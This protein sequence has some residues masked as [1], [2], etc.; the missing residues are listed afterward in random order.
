MVAGCIKLEEPLGLTALLGRIAY[1][2]C[3]AAFLAF[4]SILIF[5]FNVVLGGGNKHV[6]PVTTG[7]ESRSSLPFGPLHLISPILS[8]LSLRTGCRGRFSSPE[9][10]RADDDKTTMYRGI[11]NVPLSV[12]NTLHEQPQLHDLD[13]T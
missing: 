7:E 13:D 6:M 12:L 10:E 2:L 4:S 9:S 5:L 3:F 11:W 8:Y 1:L